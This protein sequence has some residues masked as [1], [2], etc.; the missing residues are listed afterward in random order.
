MAGAV[1]VLDV[2]AFKVAYPEFDNVSTGI[3]TNAFALATLYL[4]NDGTSPVST[5]EAQQSL[6]YL[7]TAHLLA[8]N[9][10]YAGDNP[11]GPANP[12]NPVGRISSAGEGSV[13]ISTEL[14]LPQSAAWFAQTRYGF[15]F[16]QAT[17]VYRTMHYQIGLLQPGGLP[18]WGTVWLSPTWNQW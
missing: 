16:W 7:M 15:M 18:G 4:R 10:Q 5:T 9:T 1:A 8:L 11:G 2:P 12:M 17:A 6:M 13:N 14:D 3:V